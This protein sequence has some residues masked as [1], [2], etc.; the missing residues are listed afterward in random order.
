MSISY[1]DHDPTFAANV[2]NR[3][4]AILEQRFAVIEGDHSRRVRDLLAARHA[5]VEQRIFQYAEQIKEFQRRYGVLDVETL[6]RAQVTQMAEVGYQLTLKEVQIQTYTEVARIDDRVLALLRAER[7]NLGHA[8][9]QRV[10]PAQDEIPDLA[11]EFAQ[12]KLELL[13]QTEIYKILSQQYELAKL[14]VEGQEPKL[15]L[16]ELADE[17]ARGATSPSSRLSSRSALRF[18]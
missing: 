6:A 8:E 11:G 2:V 14:E 7:E 12:L 15:Q 9:Y 10:L 1:E 3:L 18:W 16:L 5:E 17:S 4:V 13:V